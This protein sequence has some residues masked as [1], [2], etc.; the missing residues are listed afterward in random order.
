LAIEAATQ[1]MAATNTS[2][3]SRVEKLWGRKIG[4]SEMPNRTIWFL[5]RQGQRA[6]NEPHVDHLG[7][8]ESSANDEVKFD[9]E[10]NLEEATTE[11]SKVPG[12]KI[13]TGTEAG[14]SSR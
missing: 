12:A 5:R 14:T 7:G 1:E 13:E 9:A 3:I 2:A 4:Q 8:S 10:K 11:Q 6:P